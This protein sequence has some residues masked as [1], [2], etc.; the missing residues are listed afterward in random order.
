M[1]K[2]VSIIFV[3]IIAIAAP[4]SIKTAYISNDQNRT[5]DLSLDLASFGENAVMLTW[6]TDESQELDGYQIERMDDGVYR[7]IGYLPSAK[8]SKNHN[9]SY[10][11]TPDKLGHMVY[12]IRKIGLKIND[13]IYSPDQF[14]LKSKKNPQV[15]G[16][17]KQA[18]NVEI[19]FAVAQRDRVNVRLLNSLYEP[20][21]IIC[22]GSFSGGKHTVTWSEKKKKL[23]G[24]YF[25]E[26]ATSSGRNLKEILF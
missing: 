15:L 13:F 1:K 25:V 2:L 8:D 4:N 11:D 21:A 16:I 9:Y 3:I 24:V 14:E 12:R 19:Q 6:Q 22:E 18:S 5:I 26:V 10:V 20:V 17:E 23:S 7:T